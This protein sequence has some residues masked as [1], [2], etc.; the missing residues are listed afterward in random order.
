MIILNTALLILLVVATTYAAET[1]IG[2]FTQQV[3]VTSTP[4][5]IKD[6]TVK[7]IYFNTTNPNIASGTSSQITPSTPYSAPSLTIANGTSFNYTITV[8]TKGQGS[9]S[10]NAT[11]IDNG[12]GNVTYFGSYACPTGT[13]GSNNLMVVE[14]SITAPSTATITLTGTISAVIGNTYPITIKVYET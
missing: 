13:S 12:L 1:L 7:W 2:T 8:N 4:P 10:F 11:F 9:V 5:S 3:T 14:S 6:F